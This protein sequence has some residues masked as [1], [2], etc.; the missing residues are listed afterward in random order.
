MLVDSAMASH[1]PTGLSSKAVANLFLDWGREIRCPD[2]TPLKLQK[3]LFFCHAAL[4]QRTN[5]PLVRDEFE[6][7]SYGPV[8][9]NVY[10]AF[11]HLGSGIVEEYCREFSPTTRTLSTPMAI[12]SPSINEIIRCNFDIYAAVSG[13]QLSSLSHARGGPWEV[14]LHAF[15][16]GKNINR[17]I[18]NAL[19]RQRYETVS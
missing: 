13:G 11:K 4:L 12:L 7:W 6:A 10:H 16:A 2:L 8:I 3:L 18:P 5:T 17:R 9:P 19:I 14:A 1:P 15:T